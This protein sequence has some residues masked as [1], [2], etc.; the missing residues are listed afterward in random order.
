MK[1]TSTILSL[2]L[3]VLVAR[4]VSADTITLGVGPSGL[5]ILGEIIPGI[6]AGGQV[7]RDVIMIN[8]LLGLDAPERAIIDGHDYYRSSNTFGE[9]PEAV[10]AGAQFATTGD[11]AFDGTALRL[12]LPSSFVYL[13]AAWDGPNGGAEAYY[14]GDLA[15]GD[16]LV[17]PRYAHPIPSFADGQSSDPL[18]QDLVAGTKYQMTGW[19]LLNPTTVP[20]G[21]TTA[22]LLGLA[23]VGLGFV[24][25]LKG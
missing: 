25:R 1:K 2:V 8:N 11:S 14:I 20:D 23:M 15:A 17:L 21:G 7:D 19:S 22:A 5:R 3:L 6:Q 12:T 24:R 13:L 18:G 9:L 10:A 4:P 16:I